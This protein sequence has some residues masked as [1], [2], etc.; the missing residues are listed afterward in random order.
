[1][2][3]FSQA[4]LQTLYSELNAQHFDD[5]LPPCDIRWCRQLTRAAGN[6]NVRQKIIKL[7]LPIL[8]EAFANDTLFPVEYSVCGVMCSSTESATREILK[9]E[10]I[11]LWLFFQ[12]LPSGHTAQFR[13]KAKQIGQPKTRHG[14]ALPA[15]KNG[16]IYTCAHCS[17]EFPRRRRYGRAVACAS[18]CKTFA[19]G[20]FDAR[21]RLRGRRVST[22]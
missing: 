10:M 22:E 19:R 13:T 3:H 7:S 11:H 8:A 1:M 4:Q 9:H 20:S 12:G 17:H 18:C 2:T 5:I 6:I 15:P 16:W 21:F 14:I